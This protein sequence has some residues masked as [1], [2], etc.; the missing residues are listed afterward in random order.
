[1]ASLDGREEV[2]SWR[3]R[4]VMGKKPFQALA[5]TCPPA[6]HHQEGLSKPGVMLGSCAF[7]AMVV[8][9]PFQRPGLVNETKTDIH[10]GRS[11]LAQHTRTRFGVES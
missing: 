4:V 11:E 7:C 1:M 3:R 6:R 10:L 2:L 5:T 8:L 9:C